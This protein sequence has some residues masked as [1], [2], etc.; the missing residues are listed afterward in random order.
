MS[1]RNIKR[2]ISLLESI[3]NGEHPAKDE[4][5]EEMSDILHL[6]QDDGLIKL[7]NNIA[8]PQKKIFITPKGALALFEWKQAVEKKSLKGRILSDIDRLIWLLIGV[9]LTTAV[10][11]FIS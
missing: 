7:E 8:N 5:T 1:A 10:A 6:L 3:G 4:P 9:L 2:Y 11:K